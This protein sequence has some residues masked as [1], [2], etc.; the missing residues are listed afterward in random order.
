[1]S[2]PEKQEKCHWASRDQKVL[3][4]AKLKLKTVIQI[5][6]MNFLGFGDPPW[7][8]FS[9]PAGGSSIMGHFTVIYGAINCEVAFA[10]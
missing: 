7:V 10:P 9:R 6:G 4:A 3:Q 5:A 1:M 8:S 2:P